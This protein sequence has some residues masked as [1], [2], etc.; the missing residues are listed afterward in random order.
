ML[1][2]WKD[3]APGAG[4]PVAH[5]GHGP[6]RDLLGRLLSQAVFLHS[7]AL[8][9]P[10]RDAASSAR[11]LVAATLRYSSLPQDLDRLADKKGNVK[12]D[13]ESSIAAV[14][15]KLKETWAG[16]I[17]IEKAPKGEKA[18]NGEAERAVQSIHGLARTLKEHVEIHARIKL[19][20]KSPVIAWL[21][22]HASNL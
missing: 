17:I 14:V 7:A 19:D 5:I 18:S 11:F 9:G 3:L 2:A 12:S 8:D 16:E 13:Q 22:E 6:Q 10:P 20:P 21:I 1:N 4:P 15:R